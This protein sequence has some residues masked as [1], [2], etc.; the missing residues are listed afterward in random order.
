MEPSDLQEELRKVFRQ[1]LKAVAYLHGR[2]VFH[3][4][5]KPQNVLLDPMGRPIE[6]HIYERRCELIS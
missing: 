2:G 3:R 5:L 6:R 4:N 1:L